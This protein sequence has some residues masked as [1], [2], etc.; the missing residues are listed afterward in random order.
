MS[1]RNFVICCV[2]DGVFAAWAVSIY[3]WFPG[4]VIGGVGLTWTMFL[5]G[6]R[7]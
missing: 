1:T 3:G 2:L 7:P 4:F 6:S 5:R